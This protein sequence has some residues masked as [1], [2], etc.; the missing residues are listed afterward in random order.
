[1]SL[2]R[3]AAGRAGVVLTEISIEEGTD[4]KLIPPTDY[5]RAHPHV[6]HAES[7]TIDVFSE[8][9]CLSDHRQTQG[10]LNDH[11]LESIRIMV[12]YSTRT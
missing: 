12:P 4:D 9:I 11:Q 3:N 1:M 8:I 6:V 5:I 2:E 7:H 10:T